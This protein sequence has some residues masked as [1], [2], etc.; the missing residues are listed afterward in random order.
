MNVLLEVLA[1][2]KLHV[3]L[4]INPPNHIDKDLAL[5]P[6]ACVRSWER[7]FLLERL[8]VVHAEGI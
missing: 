8:P 7:H 2:L 3:R 5:L 4:N 6:F 1:A